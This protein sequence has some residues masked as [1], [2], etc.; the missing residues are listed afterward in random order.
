MTKFIIILPE[1]EQAPLLRRVA[2]RARTKGH[3]RHAPNMQSETHDIK[4]YSTSIASEYPQFNYKRPMSCEDLGKRLKEAGYT[5][6]FITT[7][8]Y[9]LDFK[10][11]GW[12][13]FV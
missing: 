8:G 13:E 6:D 4:I 10:K 7:S 12:S 2:T 11:C 1:I 5:D 3:A 9:L